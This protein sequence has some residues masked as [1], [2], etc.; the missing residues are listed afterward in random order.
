MR[1]YQTFK[2]KQ[3]RTSDCVY[4]GVVEEYQALNVI[5]AVEKCLY[6]HALDGPC[7]IGPSGRVVYCN[8][9]FGFAVLPNT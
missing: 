8:D 2:A 4:T 1:D 5:E 6:T 7:S 9:G 3:F